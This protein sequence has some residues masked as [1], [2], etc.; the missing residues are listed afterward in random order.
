MFE[1]PTGFVA[2]ISDNTTDVIAALSP[3][4]TLLL[5]VL[6]ATLVITIII[7]AFHK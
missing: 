2:D 1:L 6:L 3:V 7:R 4:T 5:G